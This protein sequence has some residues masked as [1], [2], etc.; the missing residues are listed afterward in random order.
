MN[1]EEKNVKHPS[2]IEPQKF[3]PLLLHI[4]LGLMKNFVRA[5]DRTEPAFKY[6]LDEFPRVNEA[7]IKEG[8]FVGPQS[9][10]LFTDEKFD[11]LL[12]DVEKDVWD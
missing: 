11:S 2:L 4:K 9:R 12:Y 7:K 1:I 6:L 8:F 5:M 3:L 10:K